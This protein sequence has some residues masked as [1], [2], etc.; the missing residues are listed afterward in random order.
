MVSAA[1]VATSGWLLVRVLDAS[2]GRNWAA[3]IATRLQ[4]RPWPLL[5]LAIALANWVYLVLT[6][7][8]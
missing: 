4:R 2:S 3:T 1:C 5:L 7:P 8:K 6:L